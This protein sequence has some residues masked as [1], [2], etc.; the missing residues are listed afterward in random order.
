[1]REPEPIVPIILAAGGSA[2]LPFPKA[3]AR[4]G[5]KTAL[6]IAMANCKA[7]GRPIVVL[8]ADAK[9]IRRRIP[10]SIHVVVNR[11][12]R[13]GQLSSLQAALKKIPRNA[14]FMIYP[15]DHPLIGPATIREIVLA[16]RR[17][18][19]GHEIVMPRH[20]K[21]YGHPVIVSAAVRE[22]FFSAS[23]AREV[24]YRDR[25]RLGTLRVDTASIFEDFNSVESY[26]RCLRK[27]RHKR[28]RS[29]S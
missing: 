18:R 21:R 9:L 4:F 5:R 14:A 13:K 22:E 6:Q 16:F 28:A 23:T 20:K 25:E 10:K 15:V 2:K 8:G 26:E 27:F 1:M 19:A 24:I 11:E 17:R 7:A 29:A 12:W 3:L